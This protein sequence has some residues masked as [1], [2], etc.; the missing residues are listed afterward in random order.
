MFFMLHRLFIISLSVIILGYGVLASANV[1]I[2][3][4]TDHEHA[5]ESYSLGQAGFD[6]TDDDNHC[7]H[8]LAHLMGLNFV[9][10][11]SLNQNGT[12]TQ[13]HYSKSYISFPPNKHLRPPIS[14]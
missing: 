10:K 8:G 12:S 9:Q 4:A 6:Q 13:A 14:I 3:I 2:D 11:I 5:S 1:H 7:C